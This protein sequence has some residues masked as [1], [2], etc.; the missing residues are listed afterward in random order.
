MELTNEQKKAL[1]EGMGTKNGGMTWR[2]CGSPVS[3]SVWCKKG[4]P[5]SFTVWTGKGQVA[6]FKSKAEG[7]AHALDLVAA[8]MAGP[9]P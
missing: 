1:R 4:Q 5:D 3:F 9:K 6:R 2:W 8:K 7:L